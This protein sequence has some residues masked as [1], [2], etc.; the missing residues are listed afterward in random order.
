MSDI[1]IKSARA[2][3]LLHDDLL[4]EL[5]DGIEKAATEA[6]LSTTTDQDTQRDFSWMMVKSVRRI[7]DTL[8][9]V[10]DSGIIEASRAVRRPD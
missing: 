6:W 7:R 4:T 1:E 10:V 9:G 8:Q 5:F 2:Q 3:A